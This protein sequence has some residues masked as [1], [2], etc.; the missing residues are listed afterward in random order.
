MKKSMTAFA[1]AA[2]LTTVGVASASAMEMEFN[3]R[4][5]AV[6][7]ALKSQGIDTTNI[8]TLTLSE[9]AEIKG[10]LEGDDMGNAA[11]SRIE[12]ILNN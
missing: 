4:T 10:L 5:G 12:N 1:L 3:M 8:D 2:A 7:N 9:I 6:Y 11:K